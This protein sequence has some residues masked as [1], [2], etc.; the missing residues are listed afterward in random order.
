MVAVRPL[1]E[2]YGRPHE[3]CAAV[4]AAGVPATGEAAAPDERRGGRRTGYH[5]P[6]LSYVFGVLNIVV[7]AIWVVVI[8]WAANRGNVTVNTT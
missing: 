6:G 7:C 8:I 1:T 3:Q 5:R 2:E 4:P